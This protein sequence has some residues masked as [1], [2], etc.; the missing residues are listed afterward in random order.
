M[1]FGFRKHTLTSLYAAVLRA[2][3]GDLP[4][5]LAHAESARTYR[6]W[7]D[8]QQK[9]PTPSLSASRATAQIAPFL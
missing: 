5:A 3:E 6:C 4:A 8:E 1:A 7:E 9:D 2:R